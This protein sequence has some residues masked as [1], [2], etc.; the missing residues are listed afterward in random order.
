MERCK[1]MTVKAIGISD[2]LEI[3]QATNYNK[4]EC[5]NIP[6]NCG[7]IH[8]EDA[9]LSGGNDIKIIIVSHS[10][11]LDCAKLIVNHRIKTVIYKDVYR[12]KDGLKYLMECGIKVIQM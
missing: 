5:R 10:P 12:I 4:S 7:C 3:H 2:D 1:R 8:A 11:C 6:G 9:L